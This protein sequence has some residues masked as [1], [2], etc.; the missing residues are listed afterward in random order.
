MRT[1][2]AQESAGTTEAA[3]RWR[4]RGAI[5]G[6]VVDQAVAYTLMAAALAVTYLVH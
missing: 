2:A 6:S 3:P 5:D 4:R 1:A